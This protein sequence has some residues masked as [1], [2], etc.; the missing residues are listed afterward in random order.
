MQH[1]TIS[2]PDNKV[3]FFRE[4]VESLGFQ[5]DKSQVGFTLTDE[6]VALVNAERKKIDTDPE[7]FIDWNAARKLLKA[8]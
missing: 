6:Q 2:I 7:N 3:E 4:L 8:K 5:V 1:L